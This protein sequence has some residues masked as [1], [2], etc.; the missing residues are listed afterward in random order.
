MNANT[1]A[2]ITILGTLATREITTKKGDKVTI[3][4]QPARFEY[5]TDTRFRFDHDVGSEKGEVP[6]GTVYEWDVA[7]DIVQGRFGPEL[8]RI[9]TLTKAA[10][11]APKL[12]AAK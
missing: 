5:G 12:A 7:A 3:Y 10:A 11:E 9:R 4:S 8:G 6:V 2:T 1:I